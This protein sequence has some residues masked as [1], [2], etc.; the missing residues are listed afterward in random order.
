MAELFRA[1]RGDPTWRAW[2]TAYA[3]AR[4]VTRGAASPYQA[5]VALEAWL[6]TT[7]AYDDQASL[8]AEPDALARW[9]AS[10]SAGYCQMFAAS[11]AALTRLSG[12]PARVVEGF[13]PGSLRDGVYHVTDRDAHAWVE[14]WFPGYGWLPFDATPGRALPERASSSS[15]SFDGAAAQARPAGGGGTGGLPRLRLP[16]ARLGAAGASA[17]F[18]VHA[19]A[20][21]WRGG[22]GVALL[23]VA[24]LAL[25]AV[26]AKRVLLRFALPGDPAGAAHRRVSQFAADQ[27]VELAPALTPRELAG[28]LDRQFGV[29]AGVFATA[30]E[31]AAYAAPGVGDDAGLERETVRLLRAL[32]T[33]AGRARRLRGVFSLSAVRGRAR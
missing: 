6:R 13:A 19:R 8:P 23:L 29:D 15:P 20:A 1:R 27:G 32:R 4:G 10:G 33:S 26:L 7:R 12:V 3:R 24:L 16:L 2:Q 31:R 25:A 14:A 11:L 28:E 18:G 5:V 21:W 30:L 17:D 9:A 22:R